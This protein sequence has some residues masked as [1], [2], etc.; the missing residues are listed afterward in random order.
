MP[1]DFDIVTTP[2]IQPLVAFVNDYGMMVLG[3]MVLMI[4]FSSRRFGILH[5]VPMVIGLGLVMAG[6]AH[7]M[8]PLFARL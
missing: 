6:A 8:I 4:S 5:M 7:L 3:A 2:Y 1:Y